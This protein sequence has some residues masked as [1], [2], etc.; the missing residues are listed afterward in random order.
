MFSKSSMKD[1]DIKSLINAVKKEFQ[2]EITTLNERMLCLEQRNQHLEQQNLNLNIFIQHHFE[3]LDRNISE[4]HSFILNQWNPFMQSTIEGVKND[5]IEAM[6]SN[7][8]DDDELSKKVDTLA[9]Q[10]NKLFNYDD[11]N[12]TTKVNE[13]EFK[14]SN[15]NKKIDELL[16]QIN[17]LSK[18]N[19][20][21]IEN[22]NELKL[23]IS[24]FDKKDE[25]KIVRKINILSGYI[26]RLNKYVIDD[27]FVN[28]LLF[29]PMAKCFKMSW[30]DKLLITHNWHIS[31]KKN[32]E[33]LDFNDINIYYDNLDIKKIIDH[34]SYSSE[35][36]RS[37]IPRI[38][39]NLD[40]LSH[41]PNL[42]KINLTTLNNDKVV[43]NVHNV[44]VFTKKQINIDKMFDESNHISDFSYNNYMM[45]GNAKPKI[46]ELKTYIQ[47][48]FPHIEI[49]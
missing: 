22:F 30:H 25:D 1:E 45:K 38:F 19:Y 44:F 3:R 13:L 33:I 34:S 8:K 4:N 26:S 23:Q 9:V 46:N 37:M 28:L 31:I 7:K 36:T 49:I 42:K 5:L 14:L 27:G 15:I 21:T 12:I 48:N 20:V 39:V 11:S 32:I 10:V 16:A 41:F 6:N 18:Y 40:Y 29:D 43:I 2:Q 17:N 24:N 47:T 35:T